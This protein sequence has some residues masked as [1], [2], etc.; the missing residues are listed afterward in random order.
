MEIIKV[1]FKNKGFSIAMVRAN[2]IERFFINRKIKKRKCGVLSSSLSC[3]ILRNIAITRNI[4]YY[5]YPLS[6]D[7]LH[8][9]PNDSKA[10][11][12]ESMGFK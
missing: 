10:E 9:F 5:I 6:A 7:N 11:Y 3:G 8:C 12:L 4:S 1:P 2:F